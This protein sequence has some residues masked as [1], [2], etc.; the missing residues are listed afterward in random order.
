LGDSL[1]KIESVE[2]TVIAALPH[3]T[4]D[5]IMA[6]RAA[7]RMLGRAAWRIEA[8]C[9]AQILERAGKA[10]RGRGNK[11]TEGVG[12]MARV[13]KRAREAGVTPSTIIKNAKLYRLVQSVEAAEHEGA[14][15]DAAH[16]EE[17]GV[18]PAEAENAQN[19]R[20][21]ASVLTEKEF[22]VAAQA[23]DDPLL[24]LGVFKEQ[25]L[26][27]GA[28]YRPSAAWRWVEA[29]AEQVE[30]D[31]ALNPRPP[32]RSEVAEHLRRTRA[33]LT[34]SVI[35]DCPDHKLARRLYGQWLEELDEELADLSDEETTSAVRAVLSPT[36]PR[37]AV[38]VAAATGIS[39]VA[40][41]RALRTM[42]TFGEAAFDGT[43]YVLK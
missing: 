21:T 40:A 36:V 38:D 6:A 3:W 41:S 23:C 18:Y 8:A 30:G 33:A 43:G 5:A 37:T 17:L 31:P 32:A 2:Q 14:L 35:P 42:V 9:D 4:D 10:K 11:D 24:A 28:A 27:H 1:A 29:R 26:E 7:A 13:Q 22:W 16:N 25:R 15:E 34:D 39:E 19:T 12:S 20:G